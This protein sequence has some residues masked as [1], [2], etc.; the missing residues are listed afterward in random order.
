MKVVPPKATFLGI[1]P[2][3]YQQTVSWI[4]NAGRTCYDSGSQGDPEGFVRRIIKSGHLS[5]I[6]HSNFVVKIEDY[7]EEI[8]IEIV[9][10]FKFL[11]VKVIDGVLYMAG[12]IRA[13]HET[14]LKKSLFIHKFAPLFG[15]NLEEVLPIDEISPKVTVLEQHQIPKEL[16]RFTCSFTC[17]R[18]IMA[19]LTRHRPVAFSV[20]STRYCD[21]SNLKV[22]EPWWYNNPEYTTNGIKDDWTNAMLQSEYYYNRLKEYGLKNQGA[23]AVLNNSLATTIVMTA[24][25]DEYSHIFKLRCDSAAHPDIQVVAKSLKEQFEQRGLLNAES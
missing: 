10:W 14:P 18:G 24:D 7:Q 6:E 3:D 15:Y 22:V 9:E 17:D 21:E 16:Q 5:V 20:R 11:R 13:W 1:C 4:E 23:R 12:S 19:E 2:S 25:L 8:D